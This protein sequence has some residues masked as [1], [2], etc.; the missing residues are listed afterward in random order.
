MLICFF[1]HKSQ[2][3]RSKYLNK[4]LFLYVFLKFFVSL[5]NTERFAHFLCFRERCELISRVA[6]DKRA[7]VAHQKWAT[8]SNSLRSLIK[9][10][11]LWANHSGCSP[12]MSESLIFRT[13]RSFTNFFC[14]KWAIGYEN[15]WVNSQPCILNPTAVGLINPTPQCPAFGTLL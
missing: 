15:R 5:K 8:V 9:N 10:E 14:K 4:I 7:T 12:K 3:I 11:Q 1:A 6:Y 13:N 2:A